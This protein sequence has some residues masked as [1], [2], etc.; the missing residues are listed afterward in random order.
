MFDFTAGR[1][2]FIL[3]GRYPHCHTVVVDDTSRAVIDAASDGDKLAAFHQE[4]KIDIL[5]TTHAHEDHIMYNS[6]FPEAR[7]WVHEIDAPAFSDIRA[8]IGQYGL[9]E[10]ETLFWEEF[11][12]N[13][14]NY[15]PREVDKLL[16]DGDI[17]DFGHTQAEVIHAPGH[18]PGHCCFLFPKE[19]VLFLSDYDLVKAG[20]YY[21]DVSSDLEA[22]I[23]SLNKLATVEAD[24]Y[25]T[26]HGKGI[27]EGS[28]KL[29]LNYRNSIFQREEQ[30]IDLLT[31][32]P[33]TLDEIT[34][35]GIIYGKPKSLGAWDLSLS[36][37]MMMKKHLERLEKNGEVYEE[38][39]KYLLVKAS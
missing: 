15:Y 2:K 33:K 4:R 8:L 3:G 14:C 39:G 1:I 34:A 6:L 11:L 37:R 17:I 25:L 26:A 16:R 30:L 21:G 18:T 35:A 28:P 29:I 32:R 13:E 36:E 7:L 12:K 10:K 9:T 23:S 19:K 27:F 20:P 31:T 5:I 38:N 24:T 22:T